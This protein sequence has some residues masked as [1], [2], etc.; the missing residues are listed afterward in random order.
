MSARSNIPMDLRCCCGAPASSEECV[1][2]AGKAMVGMAVTRS[3]PCDD[4]AGSL[5]GRC[6]ACGP[7]A[8][9]CTTRCALIFGM[10]H[11]L[12]C[13]LATLCND[14]LQPAALLRRIMVAKPSYGFPVA[15]RRPICTCEVA[16]PHF[17]VRVPYTAES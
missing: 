14:G 4:V 1:D 10:A 9:L 11:T 7:V 2:T 16:A 5:Q 17:T 12:E 6:N 13:S 15:G 3:L 8:A